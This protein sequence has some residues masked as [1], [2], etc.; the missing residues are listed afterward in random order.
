M[1]QTEYS[2]RPVSGGSSGSNSA[3]SVS[4]LGYAYPI[5]AKITLFRDTSNIDTNKASINETNGINTSKVKTNTLGTDGFDTREIS[6]DKAHKSEANIYGV[7][8]NRASDDEFSSNR[9]NIE[10]NIR[11]NTNGARSTSTSS[12]RKGSSGSNKSSESNGSD[13]SRVRSRKPS[14]IDIYV[15]KELKEHE[16]KV[17]RESFGQ[18]YHCKANASD[19]DTNGVDTSQV[20]ELNSNGSPGTRCC[21]NCSRRQRAHSISADT[22]CKKHHHRRNSVCVK[23]QKMDMQDGEEEDNGKENSKGQN[24]YKDVIDETQ[25]LDLHSDKSGNGD[26]L[27]KNPFQ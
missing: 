9:V 14:I 22:P 4:T 25:R 10:N 16:E 18:C 3:R 19:V 6:T 2:A 13:G 26:V 24:L 17:L 20:S 15:D 27:F 23:F 11:I 21:N 5:D 8:N 7:S 12:S 1:I